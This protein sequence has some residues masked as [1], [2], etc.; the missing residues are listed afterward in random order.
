ERGV[1]A[2]IVNNSGEAAMYVDNL[3]L[4]RERF[5]E[6]VALSE[7]LGDGL[8]LSYAVRNLATVLVLSG[9]APAAEP[10]SRDAVVLAKR[11]GAPVGIGYALLTRAL[12]VSALGEHVRAAT[13][14][15]A[16]DA[17]FDEIAS[18]P[19]PVETRIRNADRARLR[20]AIGADEFD[21]LVQR[22]CGLAREEALDLALATAG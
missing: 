4:A 18:A 8:L 10:I 1:V 9:D 3:D 16:G 17:V 12:T 19:E 13:L 11:I 6:A 14:H 7:A 22:G 2:S 21:A 20:E 15:G 5:E